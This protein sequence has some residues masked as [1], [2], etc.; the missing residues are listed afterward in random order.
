MR[1][2]APRIDGAEEI[3]IAENQHEYM[4]IT[5]ALVRYEDAPG[6]ID[7]VT[8]WTFTP[9]ERRRIANGEDIYL[10]VVGVSMVPHWL[11]VGFP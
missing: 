2:I 9:E 4:T 8:R 11:K 5:G 6:R 1:P 7:I 3:T 10:G